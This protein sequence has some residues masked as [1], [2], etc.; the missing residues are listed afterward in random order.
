MRELLETCFRAAL[1]AAAADSAV[2]ANL[3]DKPR[4]RCIVVGAGKASAAM[5]AAVEQA[6]PDVDISGVV[7]TRYGHAV[8]TKKIRIIESGHPVPDESSLLAARAMQQVLCN[9]SSDD[10]VLALISGGGSANLALPIDGVSLQQKQNLVKQLLH[11]GATIADINL[12]RNFLSQVKG[13]KLGS[14]AA[15]AQLCTLLISDIPGDS[16]YLVASGPT[17]PVPGSLQDALDV[18]A[19]YKID[20]EENLRTAM[21]QASNN[22][23]PQVPA[24]HTF[25]IIAN[26]ELALQA[27]SRILQSAGF[28]PILLGDDLQGE[29]WE[30]GSNMAE[31]AR[32][33]KHITQSGQAKFALL[34]GGET[35]V[36]IAGEYGRGG[37]NTEFLLSMAIA[38]RGESGIC[39]LACDSDGIDGTEDAAGAVIDSTTLKRGEQMGL[40]AASFLACHDSYSFFK[41]LGDL[42]LTG[43]TLTNVNDIRIVLVHSAGH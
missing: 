6:W 17:L 30:L 4:G 27:A 5:A 40:N 39:A 32:C 15:P 22:A 26:P 8:A 18:L 35:T 9:L 12:V 7:A 16:P 37:R 20:I 25:R 41:P 14:L 19:R 43:P 34:S 36:S 38:L 29:S 2:F 42:V 28:V 33:L 31:L 24:S 11:S 1:K 23:Q 10:L 13:G 3:P 21:V